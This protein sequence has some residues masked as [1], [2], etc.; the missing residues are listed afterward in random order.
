MPFTFSHPAI[1]VPLFRR[2]T[3]AGWREA[4]VLGALIPDFGHLAD[5]FV[6]RDTSH[7]PLGLLVG[8]FLA[9]AATWVFCR[10]LQPRY[11]RLPGFRAMDAHRDVEP[12]AVV[13]GAF[14]GTVSHLVWDQFTHTGS[15]L[16]QHAIFW[17]HGFVIGTFAFPLW[18]LGWVLNSLVGLGLVLFW[19]GRSMFR[20]S[21]SWNV[22]LGWQWMAVLLAFVGSAA[23]FSHGGKA[24]RIDPTAIKLPS[25]QIYQFRGVITGALAGAA[26]MAWLVAGSRRRRT[27]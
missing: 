14:L 1:V 5:K 24:L 8:P 10:F 16:S 11:S 18:E 27:D 4:L 20:E 21:Q 17:N 15:F 22:F 6:G 7:G 3:A 12:R 9:F 26:A 23:L 2:S 19:V 13:L 25:W